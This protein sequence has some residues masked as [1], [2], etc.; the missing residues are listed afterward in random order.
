M[1]RLLC[2]AADL[3]SASVDLA[4]VVPTVVDVRFTVMNM[5]AESGATSAY[6]RILAQIGV[7]LS[8]LIQNSKASLAPEL[9][10]E[11]FL[12]LGAAAK[13]VATTLDADNKKVSKSRAVGNTPATRADTTSIRRSMYTLWSSMLVVKSSMYGNGSIPY[14]LADTHGLAETM[15]VLVQRA[16]ALTLCDGVHGGRITL[17]LLADHPSAD[18][19]WT[20]S[21]SQLLTASLATMCTF[22]AENRG[23][24][25]LV[26]RGMHA[27]HADERYAS[28]GLSHITKLGT[29]PDMSQGI[30]LVSLA[31]LSSVMSTA[32]RSDAAGSSVPFIS[33]IAAQIPTHEMGG[34]LERPRK[35]RLPM[36]LL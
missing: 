6:S 32:F 21:F 33:R 35:R 12:S 9:I 10:Q 28:D 4:F 25:H 31:I 18:Q 30:K 22:C 36:T 5:A 8:L 15:D 13:D 2:V 23:A 24:K 17:S 27:S 19:C 26:L 7:T 29:L 20:P 34:S 16:T 3:A 1:L 11:Y 14:G